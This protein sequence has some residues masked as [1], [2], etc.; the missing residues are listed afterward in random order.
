MISADQVRSTVEAF[1]DPETGRPLGAMGQVGSVEFDGERVAV[2]IALTSWAAPVRDETV[3]ALR[4][5]LVNEAGVAADNSEIVTT[6]HEPPAEKLGQ[7]GV[8]AKSVIAVGSGKG[9]V[10]KSTIASLLALGLHRAGSKVG[11]MDADVYGPSVPHLLGVSREADGRRPAASA[12][13]QRRR[14]D[15]EHG[16]DGP[17]R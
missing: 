5:R 10:G 17:A 6:T 13:R 8:T 7:V 1:L 12:D 2:T 3:A 9:G 14:E 4:E 11:L 15:H 16:A